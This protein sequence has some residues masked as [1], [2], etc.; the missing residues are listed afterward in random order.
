MSEMRCQSHDARN[1]FSINLRR[2]TLGHRSSD[3]LN[4][5]QCSLKYVQAYH[6]N[7]V[8][9]RSVLAACADAAAK[10]S[11][12]PTR[13]RARMPYPRMPMRRVV[14]MAS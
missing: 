1:L 7:F 9:G 11:A 13:S 4:L 14:M 10:V 2:E 3:L 5:D 12:G 6:H 8:R